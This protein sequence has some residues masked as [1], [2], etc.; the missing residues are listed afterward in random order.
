[1][2]SNELGQRRVGGPLLFRS[3]THAAA[4]FRHGCRDHLGQAG[5]VQSPDRF[6]GV[7]SVRLSQW[8]R[9]GRSRRQAEEVGLRVGLATPGHIRMMPLREPFVNALNSCVTLNRYSAFLDVVRTTFFFG[10]CLA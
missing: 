8:T 5:V 3:L 1:M 6:A 4:G 10:G 9:F 7:W 2:L